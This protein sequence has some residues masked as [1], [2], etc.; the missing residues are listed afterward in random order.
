M[1][2]DEVHPSTS[3]L[4]L[5][6]QSERSARVNVCLLLNGLTVCSRAATGTV[7]TDARLAMCTLF[8]LTYSTPSL[9]SA[10]GFRSIRCISF[11]RQV[12]GPHGAV[13]YDKGSLS[14]HC[15]LSYCSISG[16]QTVGV[17][18]SAAARNNDVTT[19]I[20]GTFPIGE[21][22]LLKPSY[23]PNVGIKGHHWTVLRVS[24]ATVKSA[25]P[26]RTLL[27]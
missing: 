27:Q 1:T 24:M 5:H 26:V 13:E 7:S 12:A 15:I 23:S 19:L 4:M 22:E 21:A 14:L 16:N 10:V 6:L 20:S 18:A 17:L 8:I 25:Q 9:T 3:V 11:V 2:A